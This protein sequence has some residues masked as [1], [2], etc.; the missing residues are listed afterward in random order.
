VGDEVCF[1]YTDTPHTAAWLASFG[2]DVLV[3]EPPELVKETIACLQ[4]L[5]E[6]PR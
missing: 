4:N 5:A 2:A 6:D 1:S 3:L